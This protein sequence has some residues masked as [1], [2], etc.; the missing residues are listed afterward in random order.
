[1]HGQL[2]ALDPRAPTRMDQA[3]YGVVVEAYVGGICTRKVNALVA[4]LGVHS[5]IFRS[6]VGRVCAPT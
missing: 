6:Q 2:P 4:A 5:G 3:P 1:V